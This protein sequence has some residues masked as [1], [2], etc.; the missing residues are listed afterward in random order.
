MEIVDN[1]RTFRE[2]EGKLK[3]YRNTLILRKED[4]YFYAFTYVA[5]QLIRDVNVDEL[6]IHPIPMNA[7]CPPYSQGLSLAPEF[8]IQDCYVKGPRYIEYKPDAPL[9]RRPCDRVIKEVR[10][11]EILKANH[12]PNIIQY[13]GCT[14]KQNRING[15]VFTRYHITLA[16]RF[17]VKDHPLRPEIYLEGIESG[18]KHLHSLGLIHNDIN[19]RNIMLRKDDTPV[20][21]DFD[22]C[23]RAG[24]KCTSAG[25]RGWS[26]KNMEFSVPENDYFGLTKI[27]QA[28]ENGKMPDDAAPW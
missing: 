6:D 22:T 15:L 4:V 19:P 8:L 12:H 3:F 28:L 25:T 24:E 1:T 13:Q 11:C 17:E 16:D 7:I 5:R 21:I 14:V 18:L 26:L 2:V 23:Q 10:I 27:K 20:I 9:G